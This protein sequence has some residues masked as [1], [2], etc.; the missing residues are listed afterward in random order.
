MSHLGSWISALA[1]GQLCPQDAERALA[2]VAGCPQCADELAAAR[3]ARAAL[4]S[5]RDLCPDPDLTARLLAL[6]A[7]PPQPPPP[8]RAGPGSGSL[9]MPGSGVTSGGMPGDLGPRR[10]RVPLVA[11]AFSGVML[12]LLFVLGNEPDVSFEA[13]PAA[14]LAAPQEAAVAVSYG[15]QDVTA[16]LDT[17]FGRHPWAVPVAVPDGYAVA[18]VRTDTDRL[19]LDL[20]GPDGLVVVT[21]TRGRLATA[22]TPVDVAGRQVQLI[23]DSPWTVAWQSGDAVVSVMVEG[24]PWSATPVVAAYPVEAY[25]GGASARVARGW[26]L[27]TAWSGS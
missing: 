8:R 26:Q 18:A 27:L 13:R 7:T 12:V 23:D 22:G 20:T 14:A 9:P 6:G 15:G 2:H 10:S 5:S 17:W 25:D 11:G 21:Q 1:D 4:A 24:P 19:E 16:E 3:N